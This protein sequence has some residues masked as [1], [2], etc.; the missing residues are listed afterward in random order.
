MG[1][2]GGGVAWQVR[3][4]YPEVYVEYVKEFHKNGAY[5]LG[6]IQPIAVS[7]DLI[8]V[9]AITQKYYGNDGTRYVDYDAVRLCFRHVAKFSRNVFMP[10]H[11]PAIG[12]G[13][14]GGDWDIISAI[15]DEELENLDH[16]YW[17][18]AG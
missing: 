13:L 10:I 16:T 15:I 4:R 12:A 7:E 14:A 18:F 1:V 9:N 5:E 2:M 6:F 3:K 17:E 11:Y 8:I